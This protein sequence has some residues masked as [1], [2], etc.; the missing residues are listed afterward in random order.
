MPGPHPRRLGAGNRSQEKALMPFST[1]GS[2]QG[3]SCWCFPPSLLWG[4]KVLGCFEPVPGDSRSG[5]GSAR[6]GLAVTSTWGHQHLYIFFKFY[7][8]IY[9]QPVRRAPCSLRGNG[10]VF[11]RSNRWPQSCHTGDAEV[12]FDELCQAELQVLAECS[13][14]KEGAEEHSCP[15]S[16]VSLVPPLDFTGQFLTEVGA[17]SVLMP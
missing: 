14:G 5:M 12:L 13:Q 6:P 8:G 7:F 9:K 1:S 11:L 2:P 17:C 4:V 3:S 16:G 15:Y 10:E